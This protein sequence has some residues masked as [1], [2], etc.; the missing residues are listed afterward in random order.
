MSVSA[1]RLYCL[2]TLL[3]VVAFTLGSIYIYQFR[4]GRLTDPCLYLSSTV[5]V[6]LC[7]GYRDNASFKVNHYYFFSSFHGCGF[8]TQPDAILELYFA[9]DKT[10]FGDQSSPHLFYFLKLYGPFARVLSGT[11]HELFTPLRMTIKHF[12]LLATGTRRCA[13]Y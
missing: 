1:F 10:N 3:R 13:G 11:V 9:G 6:R 4:L 2:L 12:T 8:Q 5:L 7:A